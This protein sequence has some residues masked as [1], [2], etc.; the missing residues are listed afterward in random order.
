MSCTTCT[1][2]HGADTRRSPTTGR[3]ASRRRYAR[4]SRRATTRRWWTTARWGTMRCSP[5]RHPSTTCR[6][7]TLSARASR[8]SP[9]R[10][11]WKG[12]M[13]VR[14]RCW[15]CGSADTLALAAWGASVHSVHELRGY[16]LVPVLEYETGVAQIRDA[17]REL[18]AGHLI[19]PQ[20]GQNLR[21]GE[22]PLRLGGL[23]GA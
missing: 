9:S 23:P 1:P 11:R 20:A 17:F 10:S 19:E 14:S 6:C 4:G 8:A 21:V 3:C 13:A 7:C 16:E 18:V 22:A 5:S 15:P 12:W 2:T